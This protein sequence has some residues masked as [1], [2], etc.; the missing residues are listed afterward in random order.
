[1]SK[2]NFAGLNDINQNIKS[3]NLELSEKVVK[4]EISKLT[5]HI[6]N[7][8]NM[9]QL[10]TIKNSIESVGQITPIII[11]KDYKI[12]SGH[13]RYEACKQLEFSTINC[14]IRD[15]NSK[16]DEELVLYSSNLY[17]QKSNDELSQEA[18]KLNEIYIAKKKQDANFKFTK[19]QFISNNMNISE[20]KVRKIMY[21]K[22]V[23]EALPDLYFHFENELDKKIELLLASNLR[24]IQTK[25]RLSNK[26]NQI[27]ITIE[28]DDSRSLFS[29]VEYIFLDNNVEGNW[30]LKSNKILT[31]KFIPVLGFRE[32]LKLFSIEEDFEN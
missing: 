23:K 31:M 20:S 8:Y 27:I 4:I 6:D 28:H 11:S 17:R 15:F 25:L 32:L 7:F 3:T 21:S 13:T 29:L 30:E 26:N 9:D 18:T 12:L 2:F 19:M 24:D 10:E 5:P 1:M 16:L 14:I 22:K